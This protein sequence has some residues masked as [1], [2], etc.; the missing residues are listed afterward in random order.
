MDQT[1]PFV[2]AFVRDDVAYGYDVVT[3]LESLQL[4]PFCLKKSS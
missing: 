3:T 2:A 4:T 1:D